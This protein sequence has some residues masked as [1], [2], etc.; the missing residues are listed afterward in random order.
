MRTRALPASKAKAQ[1]S[2][3]LHDVERGDRV[4]ITRHGR[5]VAEIRPSPATPVERTDALEELIASIRERQRTWS[6]KP[7]TTAELLAWRHEGHKR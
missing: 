7:V 3:L 4:T 1:F 2:E 6:G 5:P